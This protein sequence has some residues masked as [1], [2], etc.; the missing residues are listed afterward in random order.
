MCRSESINN[1]F[2]YDIK[3][4]KINDR[5]DA[6]L[7]NYVH[8]KSTKM[9][10]GFRIMPIEKNEHSRSSAGF[11]SH[12][13]KHNRKGAGLP[14]YVRPLQS[15]MGSTCRRGETGFRFF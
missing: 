4:E 12:T 3:K 2:F 15:R 6:G 8:N 5:M 7:P 10:T 11:P 14:S 9:G 13:H 1:R